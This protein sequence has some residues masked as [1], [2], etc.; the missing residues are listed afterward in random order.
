MLVEMIDDDFVEQAIHGAA[1]G[2][3]EMQNLR[4]TRVPIEPSLDGRNLAGDPFDAGQEVA[5][6]FDHMSHRVEIGR[7]HVELQ[8]LMRISYAVFCLKKTTNYKRKYDRINDVN[9]EN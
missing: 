2:G 7:A 3:D 9:Y 5:L 8:S 1:H 6:L 4:A